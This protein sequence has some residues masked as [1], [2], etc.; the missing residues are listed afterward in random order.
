MTP[1]YDI[2]SYFTIGTGNGGFSFGPNY[3]FN[4]D[5]PSNQFEWSDQLSWTHGKHTFRGGFEAERVQL[6]RTYTGLEAG[7]P[8]FSSFG[9]FLIGRAGCGTG[10][11]N[12]GCNGGTASNMLNV[13]MTSPSPTAGFLY[14][15]RATDLNAFIQDDIKVNSRL[16]LNVGVRW[17]YFGSPSLKDGNFSNYLPELALKTPLPTSAA[18][19]TLAGFIVPSNY[20]GPVVRGLTKN[21]NQS[22]IQG[23]APYNDFGPRVG[24]V[25]RPTASNKWVVRG[26]GGIF[27]YC[28][29]RDFCRQ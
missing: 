5:F 19:G 7:G 20:S 27:C 15:I 14:A 22:A 25:W 29:R 8:T 3:L 21:N 16:T 6:S 17:E 12:A 11:I 9:D 2:L 13:G 10:V 24:F 26:G 23:H 4:G 18:T 28:E 1:D